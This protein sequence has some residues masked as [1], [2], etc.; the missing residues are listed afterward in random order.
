[1]GIKC[2]RVPTKTPIDFRKYSK[3][4]RKIEKHKKELKDLIDSEE[5]SLEKLKVEVYYE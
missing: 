1:M 3:I 5:K 4:I 2:P